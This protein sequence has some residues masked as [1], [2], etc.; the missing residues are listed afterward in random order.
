M[1]PASVTTVGRPDIAA[2]MTV[3]GRP[4]D[5]LDMTTTWPAANAR[6]TGETGP[7]KVTAPARPRSSTS[8][9]IS[10]A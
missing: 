10:S 8:L 9:R 6:V 4:S 3:S 1:P 7:S 5:M 2:S